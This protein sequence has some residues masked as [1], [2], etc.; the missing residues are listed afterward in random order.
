MPYFNAA[1]LLSGV[2]STLII[3]V[4]VCSDHLKVCGP[5]QSLY[6]PS[7]AATQQA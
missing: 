2:A 6:K 3:S 5:F 7:L 4:A 1:R